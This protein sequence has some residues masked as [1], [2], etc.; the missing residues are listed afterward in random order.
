K[1]ADHPLQVGLGL[2]ISGTPE[3]LN[4]SELPHVLIAGATGAGKSS[5]INA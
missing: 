5:C 1:A 4:L 3:M 2:D